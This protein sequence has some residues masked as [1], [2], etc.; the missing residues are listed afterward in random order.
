MDRNENESILLHMLHDRRFDTK[1]GHRSAH[2]H[3]QLA[4]LHPEERL[5]C[6]LK[7]HVQTVV[8]IVGQGDQLP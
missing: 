8:Y 4:K 1:L 2:T 5:E 3:F 6:H 7:E